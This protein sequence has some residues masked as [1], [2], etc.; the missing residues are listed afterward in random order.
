MNQIQERKKNRF[1]VMQTLYELTDG[2]QSIF[3]KVGELTQRLG[4]K[5]EDFEEIK[6]II[7]YLE[8]ESLVKVLSKMRNG[9]P[10]SVSISHKGVVETEAALSEPDRPTE[11]FLPTIN[12]INVDTMNQ[13]SIQQ[14]STNSTQIT[15]FTLKD[16]ETFVQLLTELKSEISKV[17]I[18]NIED[19]KDLDLE[20]VTLENQS[21][22]TR[23]KSSIIKESLDTI[24]TILAGAAGSG[25]WAILQKLSEMIM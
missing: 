13:S 7:N 12:V 22:S 17:N 4:Y 10:L 23:P 24:S 5:E 11:H 18:S 20:L 6:T 14:G 3:I 2:D 8:R 25:L 1:A 19:Q 16:K 21:K 9:F 15:T